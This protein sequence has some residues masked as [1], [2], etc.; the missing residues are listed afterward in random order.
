[1]AFGDAEFLGV[2]E[3][4][5]VACLEDVMHAGRLALAGGGQGFDIALHQG[6]R[7]FAFL[8]VLPSVAAQDLGAVDEQLAALHLHPVAGQADDALDVVRRVV[9]RELEHRDIAAGGQGAE[10]AAGEQRRRERQ[11]EARVAEA[12]F[13]D[14]E[15][16]ADQQCRDHRSGRDV[17]R[18]EGDRADADGDQAGIHDGLDVLDETT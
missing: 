3:R 9:T 8:E 2:V 11:G 6:A 1:M 15:I 10:D 14:E 7:A 13:G 4:L 16:V 5:V 12:V 17:E 18:F